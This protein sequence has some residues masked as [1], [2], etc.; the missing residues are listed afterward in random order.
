M[1]YKIKHKGKDTLKEASDLAEKR[2]KEAIMYS[3]LKEKNPQ[4]KLQRE[5]KEDSIIIT[6]FTS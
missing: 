4:E 5:G 2:M 3:K 6:S 1:D